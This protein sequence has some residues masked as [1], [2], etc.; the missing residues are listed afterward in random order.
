MK[1]KKNKRTKIGFEKKNY[2]VCHAQVRLQTDLNELL[3]NLREGRS[4][5]SFRKYDKP[6]HHYLSILIYIC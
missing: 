5:K 1:A 6:P 2:E 4:P 3:P